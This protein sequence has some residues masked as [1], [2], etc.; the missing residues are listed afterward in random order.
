MPCYKPIHGFRAP[1]GQ[2]K[3]S[4]SGAYAHA[5][6]TVSCGQCIGCRLERSRQWAVRMMHE[7]SLKDAN[8]FLTLTYDQDHYPPR[9]SLR[10]SDWQLFAKKLRSRMGKF[11][12]FHCGEYGERTRR[13]HLHAA[14]FGL[15][16]ARDRVLE[17]HTK[18]GHALYRSDLL[19]EIW[20][21]GN[22]WIGELTFESA[23]YIARYITKKITGDQAATHYGEL[24]D[25]R[26]GEI[27]PYL[28]PEYT[29]MSRRPGIGKGWIDKYL[30]ETYLF[31]EVI[32]RGNSTRPPKF[33][34]Q[35]LEKLDPEA[36]HRM[37]IK[38]GIEGTKYNTNN[39]YDRLEVRE[40]IAHAQMRDHMREI[41]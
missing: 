31:D 5:P 26:T 1:G 32:V 10:V 21:N 30:E 4:R 34:D 23:A 17:K 8:C 12:F 16:F 41:E 20:G 36:F 19:D 35:Q 37:K 22:C 13:P 3:F 27:T 11:R 33:Y 2:I 18:A 15:D 7:A 24:I 14:I 28:K 38:R 40:E 6:T 39:T 25:E 9:G 29:T